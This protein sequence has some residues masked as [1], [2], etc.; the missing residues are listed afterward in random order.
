MFA[1]NMPKITIAIPC[2]NE[3]LTI[4]K[5]INDF[6]RELP[7]ARIIVF[8]NNSTDK[9]VELSKRAGA[10][11]VYENR[12]GKGNVIKKIFSV[13]NSE[14]LIMVDGDDTYFAKDVHSLLDQFEKN[15]N[16]DMVVGR[17]MAKK[18]EGMSKSHNLGNNFFRFILNSLFKTNFKDILSGYRIMTKNFYKN[19]PIQADGFEVETEL[20]LQALDRKNTIIEVPIDYQ[21]RPKG[22][23]SKIRE[24]SDGYKIML[25]IVA[26]FR[27]YRPMTFF[28][29]VGLFFIV[30]GLLLGMRVVIEYIETGTVL[31]MPT[32]VLSITFIILGFN[33]LLAGLMVSAINRRYKELENIIGRR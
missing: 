27:D 21:S 31:Y 7:E 22:S 8:D 17:R 28:S 25:T 19:I 13:V 4:E 1:K 32:A 30:V 23:F 10:E 2:Y 9:S 20:T 24:F 33:S 12:Q 3:E 6:K 18:I 16:I 14:I 5:V 26:L 11:V 15:I 29:L